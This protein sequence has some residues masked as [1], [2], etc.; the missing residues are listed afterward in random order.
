MK[1]SQLMNVFFFISLTVP[2]IVASS[3]ALVSCSCCG[4]GCLEIRC[5][6]DS[7]EMFVFEIMNCDDSYLE[8]DFKNRIKLKTTHMYYYRIQCQML[9]AEYTLTFMYGLKKITIIKQSFQV[10][11]FGLKTEN[12]VKLF[13]GCVCYL[14]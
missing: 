5:S 8:G 3:D 12:S 11:S 10:Q 6:F 4:K 9:Q 14:N 1:N 7:R 2:Y 13:S